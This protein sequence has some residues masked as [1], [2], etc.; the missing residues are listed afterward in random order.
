MKTIRITHRQTAAVF[1]LLVASQILS[2]SSLPAGTITLRPMADTTLYEAM[3]E[4][5]LGGG[6]TFQAG[7]RPKG[8]RTRALIEFNL[9][10]LPVNAHIT[11]ATLKLTVV[12]TPSSPV[13]STFD[14]HRVTAGWG[15][16]NNS[17]AYG[18][19][20]ADPNEASWNRRLS[21]FTS[22]TN[23]GGDFLGAV[24]GATFIC[25]NGDYLFNSTA[26]LVNDLQAWH[27]NPTANFGWELVSEAE[28][29]ARSIRR[30]GSR[31]NLS[32]APN[33]FIEYTIVPEPSALALLCVGALAMSGQQAFRRSWRK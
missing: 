17:S 18:G 7:L 31:E 3:P 1:G 5:N 6:D 12:N 2:V 8:G 13:N 29:S 4:N 33:L 32:S 22:W 27:D 24:S 20:R 23:P 10:A 28:A 11:S 16:G 19:A 25:A 14:L 15:E 21:P 30:F 26:N 9:S